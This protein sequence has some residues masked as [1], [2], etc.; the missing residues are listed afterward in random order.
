MAE[1]I[2]SLDWSVYCIYALLILPLQRNRFMVLAAGKSQKPYSQLYFNASPNCRI[3][4]W[5]VER[6]ELSSNS[7]CV[8]WSIDPC[9]ACS[10]L[11]MGI[12]LWCP[13][14]ASGLSGLV[15]MDVESYTV[16]PLLTVG[17]LSPGTQ[18]CLR[19]S[20]WKIAALS[21]YPW[22]Q[23]TGLCPT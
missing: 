1:I 20:A 18:A 21:N 7:F 4:I 5:E 3:K 11:W 9:L 10:N 13:G 22:K 19:G 6:S 23:S 12:D 17:G 8:Q 2:L 16:L 15:G 14:Q